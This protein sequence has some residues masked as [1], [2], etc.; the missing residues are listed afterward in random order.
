MVFYAKLFFQTLITLK[1]YL[2]FAKLYLY[3]LINIT[4]TND[5]IE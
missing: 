4:L 2:L 1:N 5:Y 3:D